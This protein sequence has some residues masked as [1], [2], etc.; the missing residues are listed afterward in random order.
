M[1]NILLVSLTALAVFSAVVVIGGASPTPDSPANQ[2]LRKKLTPLQ[3]RVTKED[4]T[5]PPF[6]NEYWNN[7][8]E[9][10]YVCI[11][12]GE[13]LFSSKDKFDSGTGWPSFTKPLN[14]AEIEEKTDFKLGIPRTEVRSVKG[15]SHL[16]HVF[17]DGPAPTGLRYC[18]NSAALRFVPAGDFEKEGFGK[19]A[20]LF[21]KA[22]ASEISSG[23]ATELAVLGAGCFWC[24]EEIYEKVPGV[25]EVTSG[26][27]G[28]DEP[29]PTY[30]AVGSGQTGHAEV[31]EIQFDPSKVSYEKLLDIFW[32]THDPTDPRGVSPDFGSQYRSV[33]LP[34][35]PLQ[36][37][38]AELSKARTAKGLGK[39]IATEI[40]TL[41]TFYPAEAYHQDYVKNHPDDPYVRNVSKPRFQRTDL[42]AILNGEFPHSK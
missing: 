36:A 12:S 2:E 27:A 39:P 35:S 21:G 30:Q 6:R 20:A 41:Q 15:D 11:V 4:A 13:P 10:L 31:V 17:R 25:V 32:K 29:N 34:N 19:Q 33:I 5:E 18:M 22:S 24:V 28:G 38:I 23:P 1:K 42:P 40:K 14:P 3:Y 37:E 16:G 9:G 8:Q 7:K 26:Y